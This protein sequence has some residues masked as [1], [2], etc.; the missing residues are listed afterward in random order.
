MH[1]P[2]AIA[3]WGPTR[4]TRFSS[5][6]V[7]VGLALATGPR[8]SALRQA[9]CLVLFPLPPLTLARSRAAGSPAGPTT[10]PPEA[11][12]QHA[13]RLP[14]RDQRPPPGPPRATLRALAPRVAPRRRV[15]GAPGRLLQRL[16]RTLKHEC[17]HGLPWLPDKA[18]L[19]FCAVLNRGPTRQAGPLARRSTRASF[20]RAHHVRSPAVSARRLQAISAAF[21]LPPAEGGIAP[22]ALRGQALGAQLRTTWQAS[23]AG[24]TASAKRAQRQPA[25]PLC[26]ALPGAGPVCASRLCGACGAQRARYPSATARQT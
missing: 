24:D 20:S 25:G 3:A 14:Q 7:A 17:P 23:T 10:P 22:K 4:R 9:A 16:T 26:P 5:Q 1:T 13:R 21:P 11:A 6:P 8:V 12:R 15:G 2:E 19:L 18:P